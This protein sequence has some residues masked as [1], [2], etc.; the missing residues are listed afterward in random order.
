MAKTSLHAWLTSKKFW[1]I[2]QEY[3]ID[4]QLLLAIKSSYC[5]P[6]VCARVNGKQ[7][8]PFHVGVGLGQGCV[9]FPLLFI[10]YMNWIDKR[11]Y[12]INRLFFANDLVLLSSTESG[13]QR[14]LSDFTAACD[15]AGM[16]IST[17]KTEVLHL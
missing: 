2:L 7:S 16:K 11:N 5:Q 1:R 14:A 13:L 4:G 15:N 3:G 17:T 6:E 8:K 10:I 12:K 9:L